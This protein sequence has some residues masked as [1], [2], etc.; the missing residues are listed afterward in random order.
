MRWKIAKA[1]KIYNFSA[2]HFLPNVQDGH[3][4]KRLH[5]HNYTVEVE[6]RGEMNPT[7]GWV[8]DFGEIDDNMK[9]IIKKLDHYHLN[10]IDGLG[11]PT[12]EVL[13]GWIMEQYP[14]MNVYRVRVWETDRCWAEV[15]NTEGKWPVEMRM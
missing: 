9:P 8:Q 14:I 6:I 3:K 5:G 1:C 12:A 11:N 4:C 7:S 10:D 2:S 15:V 13:A